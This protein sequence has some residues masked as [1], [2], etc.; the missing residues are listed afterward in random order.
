MSTSHCIA[1]DSNKQILTWGSSSRGG[2][3]QGDLNFAN[4]PTPNEKFQ[5]SF[6]IDVECGSSFSCLL[7]L[8]NEIMVFGL[9][10]SRF[11]FENFNIYEELDSYR[12]K[13]IRGGNEV[14]V[15]IDLQG[16]LHCFNEL[17]GIVRLPSGHRFKD[18]NVIDKNI[19]ALTEEGS[20]I[21]EFKYDDKTCSLFYYSFRIFNVLPELSSSIAFCDNLF[22][23]ELLFFSAG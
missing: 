6:I 3:C 17:D 7:T 10:D 1:L 8:T 9:I 12:A 14:L 16:F 4:I 21:Y 5:T 13:K 22:F 2:L 18:V 15:F 19:F 11:D 20:L 23:N